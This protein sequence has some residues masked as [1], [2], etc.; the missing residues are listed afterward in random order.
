MDAIGHSTDR[1]LTPRTPY[2][3]DVAPAT[4]RNN[5]RSSVVS[6]GS[7]GEGRAKGTMDENTTPEP[8]GPGT[9]GS[10]LP[11]ARPYPSPPPSA[12]TPPQPAPQPQAAPQPQPQS[13]P[14]VVEEPREKDRGRRTLGIVL[15][16]LGVVFLVNQFIA[17]DIFWPLILIALGLVVLFRR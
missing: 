10:A 3:V 6:A 11:E 9:E 12:E 4:S 5:S 1:L 7:N 15:I 17:W 16:A 8:D 13:P 14:P 2:E